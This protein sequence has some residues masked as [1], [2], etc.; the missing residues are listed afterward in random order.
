MREETWTPRRRG[1]LLALTALLTVPAVVRA[2]T[3]NDPNLQVTTVVPPFS[4]NQPTSMDFLQANEIL[5]LE[6]ATGRVR[7]IVDGVLQP[8]FALDVPVNADGE[9]GL[10]GIAIDPASPPRVFLY[11]TE[12]L[13]DGGP[14][15]GNRIYRYDW[16]A[17]TG[18]LVNPVLLLDLPGDF[19]FHAG[20]VLAWDDVDGH[21]YGVIGDQNH[22]GQLQNLAFGPVPDDT[23]VIVRVNADGTPAAGN[24]YA[25]YCSN[26]VT[27]TCT[28]SPECPPGGTCLTQVA[29]YFAYGIRNCFG[30]TFDPVTA[31]LW[32]S[33]N[34]PDVYD[35]VNR[36]NPGINGGWLRIRG[37]VDRDP[38]GTVDLWNMPGEGLTYHDPEFSWLDPIAV[39]GIAFT[40]GSSWGPAYDNTVVVGDA[41][42]GQI[43]AFTLNPARDG[44]VLTGGLLDKVADN[45][46]EH[47]QLVIGQG[48]SGIVHV[49][50]GLESPNPHLYVVS[51]LNGTIYRIAGPVRVSLQGFTVE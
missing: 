11:Y 32:E 3:M 22:A 28:T 29:R 38:E 46:G 24:P 26:L 4:L 25:P 9:S 13:V 39:T 42:Q 35:E 41:N 16:N 7:W 48:F 49:T 31:A 36:I 33:E 18:T 23:G 6:K 40:F 12:A 21:L 37:P 45:Q 5:V 15:L 47:D 14:P 27:Q 17:A 43:S 50:R 19:P 34:G 20:G 10:L 30:L 44:F 1:S 51:I 2:Q 8:G